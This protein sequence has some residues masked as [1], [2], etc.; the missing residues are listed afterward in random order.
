M[1]RAADRLAR[2][3]VRA[4]SK[5][6]G[7]VARRSLTGGGQVRVS[8]CFVPEVFN[9]LRALAMAN[10]TS[11]AEEIRLACEIGMETTGEDDGT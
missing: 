8:V 11:V 5:Q 3:Y 9:R 10:G 2:G 1:K 4:K 6:P 7:R